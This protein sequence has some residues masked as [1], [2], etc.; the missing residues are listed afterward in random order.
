MQITDYIGIG[1]EN[2]VTRE[3][4]QIRSG[5]K[6]DRK[7]RKLIEQARFEGIPIINNQ[8]GSGYYITNDPEELERYIRQECKRALSGL[9]KHKRMREGVRQYV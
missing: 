4:L 9:G 2:A 3:Q 5:I 8:D 7:I 1:Q 6:D